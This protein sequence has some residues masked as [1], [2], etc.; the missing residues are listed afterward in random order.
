MKPIG[1]KLLDR[2]Q[3]TKIGE[4]LLREPR[5]RMVFGASVGF[6]INLLY[7][8]YHGVL[9]IGDRSMWF[10]S[11]CA[12]YTI[13]STTRF[14]VILCDRKNDQ[15]PEMEYFVM[16]LVGGLLAALGLVLS[17]VIYISLSENI[18]SRHGTIVMI[19]IATYTF[20]K[21]TMAIIR[22]VRYR[23]DSSPLL[24]VI[25]YVGYADVAASV[26]T[27]QRSM[28]VTF[29]EESESG[30]LILNV[31][32]GTAVCLFIWFLGHSLLAKGKEIEY[33]KIEACGSK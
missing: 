2:I 17:G 9:G 30:A 16:R 26:F 32:T 6:V 27:M 28:L 15:A 11:M 5:Y 24:A 22:A 13:L 4:Q 12:Y 33:V 21:I 7:A 10:F 19:T 23:R 31:L 1:G 29:G 3:G 25:R 20:Y 14:C 8:L 18:A